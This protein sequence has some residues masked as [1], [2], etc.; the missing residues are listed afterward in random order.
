[1]FVTFDKVRRLAF[2]DFSVV[3]FHVLSYLL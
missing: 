2:T 3:D 1:M